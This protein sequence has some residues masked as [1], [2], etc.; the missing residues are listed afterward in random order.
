M[1]TAYGACLRHRLPMFL[2]PH[3]SSVESDDRPYAV[4]A[5]SLDPALPQQVAAVADVLARVTATHK[6]IWLANAPTCQAL[7]DWMDRSPELAP[8][9]FVIEPEMSSKDLRGALLPAYDAA[10]MLCCEVR[11]LPDQFS[12]LRGAMALLTE[13]G[14]VLAD[15]AELLGVPCAV[16]SGGAEL[17]LQGATPA[18]AKALSWDTAT[19]DTFLQEQVERGY[20]AEMPTFAQAPAGA[21]TYIANVLHDWV[22]ARGAA[23]AQPAAT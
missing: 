17:V 16:W 5:L 15:A 22:V 9:C 8:R 14:H 19:L 12:L 10:H 2:G 1:T 3:W 7:T 6:L 20:P 4:V 11:S 23:I 18:Q 13:P 21:A